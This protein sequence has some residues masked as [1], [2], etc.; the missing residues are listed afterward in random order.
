MSCLHADRIAGTDLCGVD[1]SKPPGQLITHR[2]R[3][4]YLHEPDLRVF[5]RTTEGRV[6]PATSR[7]VGGA[8]GP[9]VLAGAGRPRPA[10]LR[11]ARVRML[12]QTRVS[13]GP[14]PVQPAGRY[15][16]PSRTPE[17]DTW[18]TA[19]RTVASHSAALVNFEAIAA[20]ERREAH[21]FVVQDEFCVNRKRW[22]WPGRWTVWTPPHHLLVS[23]GPAR[24][25]GT[26]TTARWQ[27]KDV[28]T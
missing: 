14:I 5:E 27:S 19:F 18:A 22:E 2:F 12:L 7:R 11:Q 26:P 4:A 20:L 13:T 24:V 1:P 6:D 28:S 10:W 9:R 23:A 16:K 15:G 21:I 8:P 17:S 25:P 3:V